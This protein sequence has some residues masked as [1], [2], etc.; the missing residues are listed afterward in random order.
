M[1]S[2]AHTN[3]LILWK[4]TPFFS[5]LQAQSVVGKQPSF[6]LFHENF[7]ILLRMTECVIDPNICGTPLTAS[8]AA[9][10]YCSSNGK[11]YDSCPQTG[12]TPVPT[13]TAACYHCVPI[14]TTTVRST[15]ITPT[16]T[17]TNSATTTNASPTPAGTS[18]TQITSAANSGTGVAGGITTATPTSKSVAAKGVHSGAVAGVA[19][20]CFFIGALLAGLIVFFVFRRKRQQNAYPQQHLPPGELAYVGHEKHGMTATTL[21][22]GAGAVVTNVD[23]LLPQ[24]AEDDAI[25]GGLS[26]I[27]DGIKNHVQ[28]YYH[29][30]PIN[31]ET[32]NEATLVELANATGIPTSSLKTLL[33]TP[34]T[35]TPTIMVFLGQLILSRCVGRTDGQTSFLPA[36]ISRVVSP[37]ASANSCKFTPQHGKWAF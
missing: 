30:S 34:A 19:I 2:I 12:A 21:G 27:R 5:N 25:V 23:R 4:A 20:G 9:S 32:V 31:H 33:L 17:P 15:Q 22:S 7:K 14:T 13:V 24:P 10:A 11:Y 28:N 16:P 26:K 35:R 8:S 18:T 36:E 3:A 37:P 6:L 29:N 1:L